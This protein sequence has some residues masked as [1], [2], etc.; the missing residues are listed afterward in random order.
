MWLIR[1]TLFGP[2]VQQGSTGSG[3]G[4]A[5]SGGK[6]RRGANRHEKGAS[7]FLPRP[8]W[9]SAIA[10]AIEDVHREFKTETLVLVSRLGPLHSGVSLRMPFRG[11][12]PR[13]RGFPSNSGLQRAN[14]VPQIASPSN[15][16]QS[17]HLQVP[18]RSRTT[19]SLLRQMATSAIALRHNNIVFNKLEPWYG[20]CACKLCRNPFWGMSSIDRAGHLGCAQA[21]VRRLLSLGAEP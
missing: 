20:S 9:A 6:N 11:C 17:N 7:G 15:S 1:G 21:P 4:A 13:N 16:P 8:L 12:H 18:P 19:G 2:L 14:P 3:V 10:L 5:S